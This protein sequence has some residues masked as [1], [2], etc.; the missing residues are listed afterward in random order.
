MVL[1]ARY[2]QPNSIF[3]PHLLTQNSR[4][5]EQI[6]SKSSLTCPSG[7]HII[8]GD[9]LCKRRRKKP[10]CTWEQDDAV[11]SHRHREGW[12]KNKTIHTHTCTHTHD[13]RARHENDK[14]GR[15]RASAQIQPEPVPSD[16][17]QDLVPIS[18]SLP[19]LCLHIRTVRTS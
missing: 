10:F 13:T 6:R 16:W 7:H 19:L 5:R 3:S 18:L 8:A 15:Q 9:R 4:Q 12:L 17:G 11:T 14:E 2:Q 1:R